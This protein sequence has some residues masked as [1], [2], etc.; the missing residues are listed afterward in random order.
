MLGMLAQYLGYVFK[1]VQGRPMYVVAEEGGGTEPS[2]AGA[3]AEGAARAVPVV[4]VR[5]GND[6]AESEVIQSGPGREPARG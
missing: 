1:N 2:R 3:R 5:S 6:L 4:T